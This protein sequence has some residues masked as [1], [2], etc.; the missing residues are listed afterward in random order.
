MSS[1]PARC[2][3]RRRVDVVLARRGKGG[4]MEPVP[5]VE[6]AAERLAS[7][8]GGGDLLA[9]LRAISELATVLVPSCVGVSLTVVVDGEAYT[10]TATSPQMAA[11]DAVQYLGGGPCGGG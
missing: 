3:L 7:L 6:S 10:M 8:T 2:D 4:G 1:S 11:L 9:S 5:E